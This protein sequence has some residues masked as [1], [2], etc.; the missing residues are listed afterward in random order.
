[1]PNKKAA[2]G[3]SMGGVRGAAG[4]FAEDLAKAPGPGRYNEVRSNV[5]VD[6][7]P[8]YSMLGKSYMTGGEFPSP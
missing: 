6:K 4:G 5:Y 3:Y 2:P 1:M 7:A 8:S